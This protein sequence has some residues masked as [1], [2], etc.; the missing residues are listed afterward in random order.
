MRHFLKITLVISFF[1]AS[2]FARNP[3][4][5]NTISKENYIKQTGIGMDYALT[6]EQTHGNQMILFFGDRTE[7]DAEYRV[8]KV[9]TTE[10]EVSVNLNLNGAPI[11]FHSWVL[12]Q[13]LVAW[14]LNKF[15][16]AK[17]LNFIEAQEFIMNESMRYLNSG[18]FPV[19]PQTDYS[20]HPRFDYARTR[21][22]YME[23]LFD[24][25]LRDRTQFKQLVYKRAYKLNPKLIT[26]KQG[27][28]S[29]SYSVKQAA[30][31]LKR[32]LRQ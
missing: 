8:S 6:Y 4:F 5:K 31:R 22:L 7:S 21:G 32:F 26:I 2:A 29:R 28:N 11:E 14:K 23:R 13:G 16:G 25:W 27:L 12:F 30:L 3:H 24:T 1:V 17:A 18:I 20:Q 19:G 15:V 9:Q 10:E